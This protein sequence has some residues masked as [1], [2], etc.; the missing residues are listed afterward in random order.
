MAWMIRS[1]SIESYYFLKDNG[2][3]NKQEF[4]VLKYLTAM[5]T[6]QT[7]KEISRATGIEINAVS[8]R[9]NS[10]KK[11]D[12]QG[13]KIVIECDKRKCTIST[14]NV[15]PVKANH[16][17]FGSHSFNPEQVTQSGLFNNG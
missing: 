8:G 2:T 1:T 17:I 14:M 9:V 7:L 12:Y 10:L 3:I 15:T 4:E 6:P 16:I 13:Q 11:K 5:G